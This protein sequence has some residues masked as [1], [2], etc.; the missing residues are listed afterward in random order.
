MLF[1]QQVKTVTHIVELTTFVQDCIRMHGVRGF[2]K[3][4][5]PTAQLPK[6][7]GDDELGNCHSGDGVK[8]STRVTCLQTYAATATL[9]KVEATASN[10]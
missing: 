4:Q 2:L 5:Q 3:T 8:P 10:V 6:V 9:W 7:R 1:R